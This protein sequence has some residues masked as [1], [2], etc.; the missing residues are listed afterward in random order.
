MYTIAVQVAVTA[1]Q[2]PATHTAPTND[3]APQAASASV[4]DTPVGAGIG[5]GDARAA[6]P[7]PPSLDD[8]LS[9]ADS[10]LDAEAAASAL[11]QL[12]AIEG[13]ASG[14]VARVADAVSAWAQ[15]A[16][17]DVA[18]EGV[19]I[20]ALTFGG[21]SVLEAK[22][23]QYSAL[24]RAVVGGLGTALQALPF[25]APLAALLGGVYAQAERVGGWGGWVQIS[26]PAKAF[27]RCSSA[28]VCF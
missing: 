11:Q 19:E 24:G 15:G 26:G 27:V 17:A 25:C 14:L 1:A 6:P 7:P 20:K 9:A 8:L 4:N 3:P 2:Q 21:R 5:T 13:E 10:S 28:V 16:P 23:V 22:F 18:A 12:E